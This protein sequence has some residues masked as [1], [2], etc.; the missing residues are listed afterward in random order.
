M[1]HHTGMGLVTYTDLAE[2][3]L[4]LITPGQPEFRSLV[5]DIESRPQPFGNWPV[6]DLTKSA[7]LLNQSGNAIVGI[8]YVWRYVTATGTA[9]TSRSSNLGSSV[10]LDVLT[11]RSGVTRD[12]GTFILPGSKRLIT[13][14][15]MFGNNLDVLGEGEGSRGGGYMGGGGGGRTSSHEEIVA[16]ELILDSAIL[17][18]GLCIGPDEFGMVESVG[19]DLEHIRRTA[20]Q[21]VAALRNGGSAGEIFEL[22][23][24]LARHTPTRTPQGQP[25]SRSPFLRMFAD[26]GIRQLIDWESGT[27]AAWFETQ[28]QPPRLRLY[29][30]S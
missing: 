30:P 17:E 14:R 7:V 19:E 9:H 24:P 8:S 25:R 18:D 21:A 16:T 4:P 13:E 27:V 20:E 15:G 23:R 10:Q 22:L 29:R 26:M 2:F 5:H 12:I 6:D 28:A 1:R 11:G 3:G